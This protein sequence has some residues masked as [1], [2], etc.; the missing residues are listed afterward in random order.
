VKENGKRE[1]NSRLEARKHVV[2]GHRL[3]LRQLQTKR[4]KSIQLTSS[5]GLRYSGTRYH[6]VGDIVGSSQRRVF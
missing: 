1:V 2:D 5:E 4:R 6:E 3:N